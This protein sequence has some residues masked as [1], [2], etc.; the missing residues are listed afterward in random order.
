[1]IFFHEPEFV[2]FF[3][4]YVYFGKITILK[5]W[6]LISLGGLKTHF[7]KLA[8]KWCILGMKKIVL[9]DIML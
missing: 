3:L 1:M 8:P 7:G 4:V 9:I 2:W 6:E 5:I